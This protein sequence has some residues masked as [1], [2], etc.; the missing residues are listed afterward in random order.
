MRN[1]VTGITIGFLIVHLGIAFFLPVFDD[2]AYYAL[3]SRDLALGYYD[4]PPMIAY[5]IGAGTAIFGATG[6]GIRFFPIIGMA[7]AGYLVGQITKAFGPDSRSAPPLATLL[8]NLGLAVFALG[9]F[10]TPD[11]PSVL[12]WVAATWAAVNAIQT[13]AGAAPKTGWWI[14]TGLLIGFGVLSKFTN[15]FVGIG[16]LGYLIYSGTG[17]PYLRTRLPYL[18]VLAAVVPLIPYLVWN[19]QS[20]WLGFQ[21]QGSRLAADGF[22]T[23]YLVEFAIFMFLA[24][25]PL[26]AIFAFRGVRVLRA[27]AALLLWSI[28][29]ATLYFLYHATHAAVQANW[30]VP[31]QAAVAI[32]A[33]FGIRAAARQ[34][35]W[36]PVTV[37]SAVV[38]TL[39]LFAIAFNP[40]TPI[41]AGDNPPNQTRGWPDARAAMQEVIAATDAKWIA[42]TDYA[43]TGM[44]AH[45]F[46]QV[47]VWSVTQFERYGFRGDFPAE[48]CNAKG[49]L[50]ERVSGAT[51][52]DS[53]PFT[54]LGTP[55]EVERH[56]NGITLKRYRLTPIAGVTSRTLCP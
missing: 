50:I 11:A 52:P 21:R 13:P 7:V 20:D 36:R 3:W 1:S 17:R 49:I 41:G 48:L 34:W 18:A 39:G 27:R 24:P 44:L 19:V 8:F 25:T 12:F 53:P 55:T 42:T 38:L 54:T 56:L 6:F 2:E 40:V 29:P 33:A 51:P 31:I 26:V 23:R 45:Q 10:A 9:N 14:V 15:A 22:T 4:H 46:A 35:V 32:L 16:L 30:I 47:P 5:M 37:L 28:G 43:A